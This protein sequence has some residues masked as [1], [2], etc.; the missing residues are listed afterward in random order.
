VSVAVDKEQGSGDQQCWE[1]K[2]VCFQRI[3]RCQFTCVCFVHDHPNL[4]YIFVQGVDMD[5]LEARL[6]MSQLTASNP[7]YLSAQFKGH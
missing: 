4:G 3:H 5:G 7:S 2:Q 1:Q 6:I